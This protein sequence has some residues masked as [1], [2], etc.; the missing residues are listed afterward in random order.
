MPVKS[1]A[2]S[3]NVASPLRIRSIAALPKI[4]IHMT[5]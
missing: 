4:E 1:W 2:V 5:M 3:A